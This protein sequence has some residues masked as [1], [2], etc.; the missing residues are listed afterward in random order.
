MGFKLDDL[1][2]AVPILGDIYSAYSARQGQ[3]EANRTNERLAKENRMF[4]ERMS[5]TAMQ[6]RVADLKAAGLNPMLAAGD[7]GASTPNVQPAR[8]ESETA[9]S[10]QH[11]GAAVQRITER[12]VASAN[13]AA[14]QS[15]A[16]KNVAEGDLASAQAAQVRATTPGEG[17]YGRSIEAEI[18]RNSAS[19]AEA[20]QRIDES[21]QAIGKMAAEIDEIVGRTTGIGLENELRGKTMDDQVKAVKAKML[22]DLAEAKL[23]GNV[24]KVADHY[25]QIFDGIKSFGK[26]TASLWINDL[27]DELK[28]NV[29]GSFDR[30]SERQ[31]REHPEQFR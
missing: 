17:Q 2:G 25:M 20:R 23:K 9:L 24:A 5:S 30:W 16:A 1:W 14:A 29:K 7:I 18:E 11:I 28:N 27:I 15:Q 31:H 8:V 3:S 26:D 13:I 12:K 22:S 4:E 6:R 19:A 21:K 10:S